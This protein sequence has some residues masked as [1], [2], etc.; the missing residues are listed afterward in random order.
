MFMQT[1]NPA[2]AYRSGGLEAEALGASPHGLISMLYDGALLSI[3]LAK[4][5]MAEGLVA[6]K[7]ESINK[8]I[9]IIASGLRASLNIRE[10]GELAKNLDELYEYIVLQLVKANLNNDQA[11]LDEAHRLLSELAGAWAKMRSMQYEG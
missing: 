6:Q 10:G 4:A 11:L 7:S 1:S 5:R 8:A 9:D 2:A 3:S